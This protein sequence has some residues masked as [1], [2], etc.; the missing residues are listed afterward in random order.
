ML[1]SD[2]Y[3]ANVS[4]ENQVTLGMVARRQDRLTESYR[5]LD[6]VQKRRVLAFQNVR[7]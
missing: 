4:E 7:R 5:S 3:S 1:V 6:D 2:L